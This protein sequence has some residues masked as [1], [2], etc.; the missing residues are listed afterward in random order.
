M[1]I[2]YLLFP[3]IQPLDLVGPFD[4]FAQFNEASQYLVWRNLEPIAASGGLSLIPSHA[5][6]QCPPLDVLCVPG[7]AG[8]E[9]LMEDGETLSFIRRQARN[10]RYVTSV[11]TGA[12]LLGAA[13]LLR[14]KQA[15]THWAYH[16]LLDA[17]GA[18]PVHERVVVDDT[19]VTGGGVTAGIDFALV[20]AAQAFGIERAQRAQLALE[21]A[22]APPFGGHPTT[23]TEAVLTAQRETVAPSVSRRAEAVARAAARLAFDPPS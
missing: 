8:V 5:F 1:R 18:I 7:G 2:G 20:L 9:L 19:L 23:A 16:H 14:G 6:E 21:Y 12:L 17:F 11:C 10:A 22:P 3:G 13:G 15:T 4:V